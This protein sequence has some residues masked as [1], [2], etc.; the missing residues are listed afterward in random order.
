MRINR[1][2][3]QQIACFGDWSKKW[4][5]I[6]LSTDPADFD[7]ASEA[8]LRGYA[9]CNLDKPM[10]VLRMGSPYGAT[11]GGAL[12]WSLLQRLKGLV[13]SQ[14]ESR[15]WSQVWSQVGS[16]VGYAINNDRGGAFWSGWCAYISFLRDVM[17]W[18]DPI[19][20]RFT[21]DE[22]LAK[23]CGWVWW[24]ENVLAISD[25]PESI[26]RDDQGRLHCAD[27]PSIAYRDGWALWH[28]H[29]LSIPYEFDYIIRSPERI[30]L[31]DIEAQQNTELRRVMLERYGEARYV[32]NSGAIVVHQ[33][34][35]DHPI[36][37]LRTAR[38]L[39]KE[40]PDDEP[41]VYVDLLNSTPEP[42]GTTKRY[43]LR[44]DPNAYGGEAAR[45]AHAAAASTWRNADGSLT[46]QDWR[47]YCPSAES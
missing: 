29:G 12:A 22:Q 25:R 40:L 19:L 26:N 33:L 44:V 6:G 3:K 20:E 1:I 17:Q 7:A 38:V 37:G 27:G 47:D 11:V 45:N 31:T 2:T 21:I 46:Y 4:I 15:V 42:D 36:P 30:T 5:E 41:F 8:A 14:V 32:T 16:Q 18:N 10:V 28:W 43:M 39:R 35:D 9:L 24:H 23:S 34:P 13:E